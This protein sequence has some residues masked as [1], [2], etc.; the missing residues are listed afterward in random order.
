MAITYKVQVLTEGGV[1][2][3]TLG[4][5]GWSWEALHGQVLDRLRAEDQPPPD[6]PWWRRFLQWVR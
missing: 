1:V 4:N 6:P 2:E 5:L 3:V